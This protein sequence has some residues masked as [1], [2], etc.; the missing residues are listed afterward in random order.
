[1]PIKLPDNKPG[2]PFPAPA[3]MGKG[4]QDGG[5]NRKGGQGSAGG[6]TQLPRGL[7]KS[8][9]Q[10]AVA[11]ILKG[12]SQGEYSNEFEIFFGVDLFGMKNLAPQSE[13]TPRP[14]AAHRA[15]GKCDSDRLIS[16][17]TIHATGI[18]HAKPPR[19]LTQ[20]YTNAKK[21]NPTTPNRVSF[22]ASEAKAVPCSSAKK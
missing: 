4:H 6:R 12:K 2:G 8:Q 22:A 14:I 5:G 10:Q 20:A 3:M 7:G 1:M 9:D 19:R 16:R 15:K 21:L 13:P 11:I 17:K 18:A